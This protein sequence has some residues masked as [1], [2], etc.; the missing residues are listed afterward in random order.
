[1]KFGV[2]PNPLGIFKTYSCDLLHRFFIQV[3]V[4][5]PFSKNVSNQPE[6]I[7]LIKGFTEKHISYLQSLHESKIRVVLIQ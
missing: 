2:A 5:L 3:Y 7:F 6:N 1:M 4:C